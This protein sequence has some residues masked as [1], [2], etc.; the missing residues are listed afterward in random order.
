MIPTRTSPGPLPTSA[1][2]SRS[3]SGSRSPTN[4]NSAGQIS[5]GSNNNWIY[6]NIVFDRDRYN[7][8]RA[9]G[10]SLGAGRVAFGVDGD[11]TGN[12]T[13]CG[14][15]SVRDDQWHHIA[16]QR[17]SSDGWMWLFVDGALQAQA[18][19][20]D[21][22]VSYPDNGVPGNF[23][24]GR[25]TFS[26]PFIVLGAE[27]HD[28]G[29]EY[30]SFSGWLDEVRISTVLRYSAPFMPP[31]QPFTTG[32]GTAA[33]YHFDEPSGT[34]VVDENGNSS[35][36]FMSVGANGPLRS[37]E[38]PFSP[39]TPT[40]GTLRLHAAT[41][42]A[43]ENAANVTLTVVRV[44]GSSGPVSV[45]YASATGTA[46]AGSDY[47]TT[48]GTATWADG[49]A[50]PKS[51]VV[52]LVDD[53]VFE[54][55]ETFVVALN[56]NSVT[57]GATLGS[58][59][60]ATVTLTDNEAAPAAGV[61]ELTSAS[62]AAT[63]G[64]ATATITVRRTNGSSGVVSVGYGTT[65]GTATAGS[66]YTTTM[67]TATWANGDTASKSIV[68]PLVD[69][70]VFEGTE[71]FRVVLDGN[72]VTG[73]A[74]LG[75][76]TTTV[77]LADNE[78]PPPAGVVELTADSFAASEGDG[79]V[80]ITVR[81]VSG[82]AGMVSVAYA[83]GGG[84]ATAGADYQGASG[85]LSWDPGQTATK[86]FAVTLV[87]DAVVEG[88]E[89]IGITLSN[90]TGGAALG[91]QSTAEISLN[92]DDSS[93]GGGGGSTAGDSGGG[94]ALD[95][96]AWAALLLAAAWQLRRR[97]HEARTIS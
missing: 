51:I 53:A 27:K 63:E 21:G 24:G 22:D 94:G 34:N 35:P 86:S 11:G 59:S 28:A 23:C 71:T 43:A 36:G 46:T 14:T 26:D 20:P 70:A 93:G 19:G 29:S 45:A 6:G 57:G 32:A 10:I 55:A 5:C 9:Y 74:T 30:P 16:V 37:T 72:S 2:T 90:V 68:V 85:T 61:I 25:C 4:A 75:R 40:P 52:P 83:T 13:I 7:Q 80:T 41:Y 58:P 77:T 66:D 62:F 81:R 78:P 12:T 42:T 49:D 50:A 56:A 48:M 84:T 39:T 89:T 79:T 1:G 44:G 64:D 82:S 65:N 17:Q 73:G 60:S 33:L 69:D 18:D 54:G 88:A 15:A 97:R 92:D 31:Q 67:G 87:N 8:G 76:A 96:V 95:P 91:A 3:S 38:T 47:T